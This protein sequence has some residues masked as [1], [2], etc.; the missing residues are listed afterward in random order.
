MLVCHQVINSLHMVPANE[1]QNSLFSVIEETNTVSFSLKVLGQ[2]H[3]MCIICMSNDVKKTMNYMKWN[4]W[5]A[6]FIAFKKK[7]SEKGNNLKTI[8]WGSLASKKIKIFPPYIGGISAL[9]LFIRVHIVSATLFQYLTAISKLKYTF[10]SSSSQILHVSVIIT[11]GAAIQKSVEIISS[12]GEHSD[13][14]RLI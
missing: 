2:K 3:N 11:Y 4:S 7:F 6:V 1:G 9:I 13:L 10:I 5:I 12:C 8:K 14:I